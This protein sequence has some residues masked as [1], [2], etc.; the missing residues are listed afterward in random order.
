MAAGWR[1]FMAGRYAPVPALWCRDRFTR[2]YPGECAFV[3]C[4]RLHLAHEHPPIPALS[5]RYRLRADTVASALLLRAF[6]C[7]WPMNIHRSRHF[8]AGFSFDNVAAIYNHMVV[9]SLSATL[10]A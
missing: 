6:A 3:T 5:C 10:A 7:I 9:D 8:R 1:L 4:L 2:R